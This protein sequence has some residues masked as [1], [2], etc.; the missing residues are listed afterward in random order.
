MA[1]HRET[2]NQYF[3]MNIS[4]NVTR[5]SQII[6]YIVSLLI[7]IGS[8]NRNNGSVIVEAKIQMRASLLLEI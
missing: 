8:T 7:N 5:V 3:I 4:I 6:I 1:F 2:F